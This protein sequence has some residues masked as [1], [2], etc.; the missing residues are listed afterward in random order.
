MSRKLFVLLLV[1]VLG[2]SLLWAAPQKVIQPHKLPYN[3]RAMGTANDPEVNVPVAPWRPTRQ[4]FDEYVGTLD[5][6]GTTYYDYQHNGSAGKM[7]SVDSYGFISVVWMNGLTDVLTGPRYV[8]YNV[9]DPSLGNFIFDPG[10]IRIDASTRSGYICQATSANGFCFPAFHQITTNARA[11]AAAAGD[12]AAYSD[13]YS[14]IEPDWCYGE[15]QD[16]EI[17]WPKIAMDINGNVHMMSHE[18]P[19]GSDTDPSIPARIYYSRGVPEYDQDG[20]FLDLH[21]DQMS[22]GGFEYFDS[23]ETI[24]ANITCSRHSQR[25][26]A[27]WTHSMDDL[28][29]ATRSQYNNEIYLRISE[30][31]GLN[32]GDPVNVTQWTP[33]DPDCWYSSFPDSDIRCD[34]DTL[35]AYTDCSVLFDENDYLHVAFTVAAW[36]WYLPGEVDTG[37]INTAYSMVY[38]WGEDTHLYSV[39]GNGWFPAYAP[40]AWQRTLQRPSLA[41]DTT[42]DY[43]Y[44]SY[45]RFDTLTYSEGGLPIAD[46]WVTVSTNNGRSWAAGTNVTNTE[47]ENPPIPVPAGECMNE[48]DITLADLVTDGWVHMEYVLDKDAGGTP[49]SEGIAT[50]NPVIYQRIPAN[51]IATTP[52]MQEYPMHWDSTG[53]PGQSNV[54]TNLNE[55]PGKFLLYQ[56]YPNPFN[57][58]TE[59]QFDLAQRAQVTLKVYNVLGQQVASLLNNATLAAGAHRIKFDGSN[60][61][62]GVYIYSLVSNGYAASKK[63][64]LMK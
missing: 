63:M 27:A 53:F 18:N 9:W 47:G 25:V 64:V 3:L 59:L 35:R 30:D 50:L 21:W 56:N 14:T 33:W 34:R 40:G 17:I 52:L 29:S 51:Q 43:L 4:H 57:P 15:G 36:W 8:Y 13:A 48:R 5:T 22:C 31:G 26:A 20:Y 39:I 62:S 58:S 45:Q 42:N 28:N 38:H 11:H 60:L 1:G 32:W 61:P 10:G 24:A 46:A 44:C 19:V 2:V 54:M 6:A 12:Y 7:V 16:L 23:V 55:V 41:I 37:W 49:Q